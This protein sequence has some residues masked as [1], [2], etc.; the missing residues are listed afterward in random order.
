MERR[1]QH[2]SSAEDAERVG[3]ESVVL[4]PMKYRKRPVVIEA[5]QWTGD[6]AALE[7]WAADDIDAD[8]EDDGSLTIHTLEGRMRA[9][10]NDWIIK[11]IK[12][13]FYPCKPD[14]FAATYEPAIVTTTYDEAIAAA[15]ERLRYHDGT[16]AL[17]ADPLAAAIARLAEA[18]VL[19]EAAGIP[20]ASIVREAL[21][22]MCVISDPRGGRGPAGW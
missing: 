17:V 13:E 15:R 1:E 7:S 21:R 9:D 11:G 16:Y 4:Q 14:I 6:G 8:V 3:V 20:M 12:G 18:A 22:R 19:L 10:L 5:M 2:A